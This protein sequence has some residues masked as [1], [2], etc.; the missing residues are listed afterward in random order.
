[1]RPRQAW[2]LE[3]VWIGAG[4]ARWGGWGPFRCVG[5]PAVGWLPL[6]EEG[7][8]PSSLCCLV[9]AGIQG[10]EGLSGLK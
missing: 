10:F 4:A 2:D 7:F 8:Q 1:M 6:R 9:G 3:A 5:F